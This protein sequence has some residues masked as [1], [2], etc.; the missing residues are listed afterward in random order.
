MES[1]DQSL[2]G[3]RGGSEQTAEAWKILG[4][5]YEARLQLEEGSKDRQVLIGSIATNPGWDSP[6]S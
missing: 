3:D 6:S 2:R 1:E 4:S 5:D